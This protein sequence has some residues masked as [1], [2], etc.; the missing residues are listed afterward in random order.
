MGNR[1]HLKIA[2]EKRLAM[3]H[4]L[5]QSLEMLKMPQ[6]ELAEWLQKEIEQ[7]PLLE[8]RQKNPSVRLLPEI[9]APFSMH[10]HILSQIRES[11]PLNREREIAQK[12]LELLDER[13]FI[14]AREM[15]PKLI[16]EPSSRIFNVLQILQSFD[17]PGIFAENLQ[18]SLI[19]QLQVQG[20]RSHEAHLLIQNHFEDLL[21]GRFIKI[22]KK[23][24]PEILQNG[25]Q[26]IARLR[27]R[28]S[29]RSDPIP[30]QPVFPD[31]TINNKGDIWDVEIDETQ[32]PAFQIQS[33][34]ASLKPVDTEEQ[35]SLRNWLVSAKW[36]LRSLKRRKEILGK[37]GQFLAKIQSD[38]LSMKGNLL[39]LTLQELAAR[40]ELHE[41]TASRAIAGKYVST[42]RGVILLRSLIT[43]SPEKGEAWEVLSRLISQ[44]NKAQPLTDD[45]LAL[46]LKE[47]GHSVARRTV[48]KYRSLLKIGPASTRKHLS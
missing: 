47:H 12:L 7:N 5:R 8:E 40:L 24:G 36:I 14:P 11:F 27:L 39:P 19:L 38:Y 28:M 48:A 6:I 46:A 9:E 1:L 42:P 32:L 13:G 31:L 37:I 21:K 30:I 23:I 35:E 41:S 43:A 33:Q 45:E 17:P 4:A 18:Q 2:P 20:E 3:T 15:L 10:E 34:Y 26:Q 22:Q 16:E 29:H 25:I 44:E